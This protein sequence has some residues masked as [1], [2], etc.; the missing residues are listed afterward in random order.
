MPWPQHLGRQAA[1]SRDGEKLAVVDHRAGRVSLLANAESKDLVPLGNLRGLVRLVFSPDG[2][3]V[4]GIARERLGS[5]VFRLADGAPVHELPR[6]D[7]VAFSPDGQTLIA[8]SLGTYQILRTGTWSVLNVLTI[9]ERDADW[10]VAAFSPDGRL[11]VLSANSRS[12][13]LYNATTAELLV[14]LT[15]PET[16]IVDH[17]DFSPD[18]TRLAVTRRAEDVLI[19]DLRALREQLALLDLDWSGPSYGPDPIPEPAETIEVVT[20]H[21]SISPLE[22]SNKWR[23]MARMESLRNNVPDAIHALT[24]ALKSLPHDAPIAR[25]EILTWR[26]REYQR[27]DSHEAAREDWSEATALAPEARDAGYLLAR[28]LVEG[29]PSV[30]DPRRALPLALTAADRKPVLDGATGLLGAVYTRLG[31]FEEAGVLLERS[32]QTSVG[33]LRSTDLFFLALARAGKGDPK[34]ADSAFHEACLELSRG[35][36]KTPEQKAL[37][38]LKEEFEGRPRQK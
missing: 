37:L 27:N 26:G 4:V 36:E 13:R 10:C 30:R 32:L 17:L 19:W 24:A 23:F 31:R 3:W 25:A 18:G 5:T 9:D 35:R 28:L 12:V 14:A 8:G 16:T 2:K 21:P 34:G 22:W 33:T 7:C 29:P 15:F 20:G 38:M 1:W 11:L 6:N